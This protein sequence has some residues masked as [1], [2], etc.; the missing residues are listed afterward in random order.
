MD[1]IAK[2]SQ[3]FLI[4]QPIIKECTQVIFNI[5]QNCVVNNMLRGN[6]LLLLFVIVLSIESYTPT[7]Y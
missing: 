5:E 1:E 7:L 6:Y 3:V 4:K 2:R